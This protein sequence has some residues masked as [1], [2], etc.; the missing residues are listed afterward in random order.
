MCEYR[1]SE[2]Q[3]N[4]FDCLALRLVN[5]HGKTKPEWE[6][7]PTELEGNLVFSWIIGDSWY[8]NIVPSMV[9]SNELDLHYPT[10]I[11]CQDAPTAIT[12]PIFRIEVFEDYYRTPNLYM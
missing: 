11:S 2:V 7:S 5:G 4:M 10:P 9:S 6:L 12:D 1:P 3:A 8:E